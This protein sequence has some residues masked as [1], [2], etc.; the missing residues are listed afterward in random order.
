MFCEVVV[1]FV[2]DVLDEGGIFVVKVFVGGV[3]GEL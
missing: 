2:F 1:Y 3:E